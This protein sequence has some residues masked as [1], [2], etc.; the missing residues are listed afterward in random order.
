MFVR[1]VRFTDVNAER[2][3]GLLA[4]IKESDGPPPGVPTTGLTMLFD[5]QEFIDKKLNGMLFGAGD[6]QP[7]AIEQAACTD[8]DGFGGNRL[9]RNS[10][11]KLGGGSRCFQSSGNSCVNILLSS[12][13]NLAVRL[14]SLESREAR[15]YRR[16]WA[17]ARYSCTMLDLRIGGRVPSL[18]T[19][20]ETLRLMARDS[21]AEIE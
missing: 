4:R 18:G 2:M 16:S 14:R 13:G 1:V 3:E 15:L 10:L 20:S 17:H 7:K 21:A 6:E 12:H 11:D 19:I 5:R 8:T 9:E